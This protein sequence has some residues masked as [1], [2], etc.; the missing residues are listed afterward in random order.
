[1]ADYL[2]P[3]HRAGTLSKST[4]SES[5]Q[6]CCVTGLG[7]D[8][9]SFTCS[10]RDGGPERGRAWPR[11]TAVRGGWIEFSAPNSESRP[12]LFCTQG[13]KINLPLV[14]DIIRMV[15]LSAGKSTQSQRKMISR[16]HWCFSLGRIRVGSYGQ[17]TGHRCAF[18]APLSPGSWGNLMNIRPS[19][20]LG[21]SAETDQ[22][23]LGLHQEGQGDGG[24]QAWPPGLKGLD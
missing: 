11:A 21:P 7:I 12:L 5:R 20:C 13:T 17:Q 4:E 22:Q 9:N 3:V 16:S 1:M 14:Q 6:F 18:Q 23:L 24:A 2:L 19:P 10:S 15:N 8:S